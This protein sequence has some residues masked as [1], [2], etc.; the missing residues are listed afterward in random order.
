MNINVKGGLLIKKQLF[1]LS[2]FCFI[3][4][5]QTL[6]PPAVF[7]EQKTFIIAGES[8]LAPFSFE[9]EAGE[10]TGINI[11]LMEEIAKY[12]GVDFKYIPM[13]MEE[14]EKALMNG[15]IDAIVGSTYNSEKDNQL[16]FTQSYFT[17]SQSIIIPSKRKQDIHTLTDL[18]D[19]HVVLDHNTPVISTFLNMR[20]TNL[21]TVSNQYSGILTLLNNRA[22]VFIGNKWTADFYLKKFRQEKNYIILDEVIEPADYTIAVKKGNQSLLF[23]MDNTLT[24]LKANRNINGIIDKWV[25]PQ[26]NQKIARLEQF[27]FWLIIILTAVALIL[28]IIYIWNQKLKKS[29]HNQTLKLHLLNKDLEKQR[30]NIANGKA[31]KDQILNNINTGI[32][33]F[34][35]DFMITSC[36]AKASDIL[37]IS[38]EMILN[39]M[40]HSQ[41]MKNFEAFNQEQNEDST[42]SFR[43]LVFDEENE[44][45]VISYSMHKMFNSEEMQT[46]YLLSMNDETEKKTLEK[47]LVTQEKL[48]ALGQLVAGVAHEIR[49]PLTSIKTFIDLLPSKYDNPQFRQVLMEHLP[50]EVNRLN[51]IV[52][53]LIE[54]ARPRPPN[55]TNCYAHELISL[56][57]FHKVTME[58][59]QI[60]FEQTIDDDLIFYIDLQQ[61]HQ[62]L[63]NLV[64]NSIH[65]VEET[66]EKN[67]KITIDKENE[68]TG[69]ITISDTGKGMKQE[70]LNHIFEPFF[71]NKEKGVGLGL[72]L[73]Y[74]LVK[75]NN[76]DIHVKSYP[77]SGT[78]FII[79]LPL[80]I[81]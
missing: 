79:L 48:H 69:R 41:L 43:I 32:I 52:T 44:Q 30:Q 75:E 58:K 60:N 53:D 59:K 7:A 46:G 13:G 80:Y 12:N 39:L 9:N 55:I 31:F 20:N 70:E 17:M 71:T 35:L 25:M 26:S 49:N 29:V 47:K 76:G 63:L 37:N 66:E 5:V 21:T 40:N 1:K 64:L 61:I 36:N 8:A 81:E 78:K 45:K 74:R 33:T 68:K 6:W 73:S 50:T 14:A 67:I 56:L 3:F 38:K 15:T 77:N 18:R 4:F 62:V 2:I 65:A 42:G 57:A 19:S 51:A 24:E 11:D 28:L 23:M 16:D 54:Y 22:D 10:L 27:I 72:T 34:D